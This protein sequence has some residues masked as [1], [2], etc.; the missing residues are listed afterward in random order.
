M[1]VGEKTLECSLGLEVF[2]AHAG[3]TMRAFVRTRMPTSLVNN[4]PGLGAEVKFG[5]AFVG[6]FVTYDVLPALTPA[7]LFSSLILLS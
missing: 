6:C 3:I 7:T 1:D 2:S 5:T 4:G